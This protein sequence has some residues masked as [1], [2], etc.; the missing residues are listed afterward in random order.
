MINFRE[1]FLA[2]FAASFRASLNDPQETHIDMASICS[3]TLEKC[4]QDYCNTILK[5]VGG[6]PES[7]FLP[8]TIAC[9]VLYKSLY[10]SMSDSGQKLFD[11]NK[12]RSSFALIKIPI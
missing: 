8:M 2:E 9:Y 6:I 10:E 7:N 11:I 4:V 3:R 1:A 5:S 12:D